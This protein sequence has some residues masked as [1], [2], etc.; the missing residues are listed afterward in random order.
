MGREA[1]SQLNRSQEPTT[2]PRQPDINQHLH[3]ESLRP[4]PWLACARVC[5]GRPGV[6]LR[7]MCVGLSV[8]WPGV[9]R[10]PGRRRLRWPGPWSSHPGCGWPPAAGGGSPG[11]RSHGRVRPH[12]EQIR[13]AKKRARRYLL[14]VVCRQQEQEREGKSY[15]G[16]LGHVLVRHFPLKKKTVWSDPEVHDTRRLETRLTAGL[17]ARVMC[18]W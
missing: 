6:A 12:A 2:S 3:S 15:V 1:G 4:Q 7:I 18:L 8:S 10:P 14:V 16:A 11:D 13:A 9:W 17:K 5:T